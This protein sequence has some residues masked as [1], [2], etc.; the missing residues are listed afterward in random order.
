M[1]GGPLPDVGPLGTWYANIVALPYPGRSL[2]L[3][4]AADTMLSVVAPGRSLRTTVPVFRRRVPILLLRLG[5][6]G[7]WIQARVD[8]LADVHVARAGAQTIDRRVLGTMSDATYQVRAEAEAVGTFDRLDLDRVEDRLAE[9]PL[10][11]LRSERSSHGFPAD[12]VA[13]L[14][15]V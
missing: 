14:A 13:E 12:A 6:P 8:D 5:L 3:F 11:A 1:S 2:V 15:G 7:V 4:T 9:V 10:G